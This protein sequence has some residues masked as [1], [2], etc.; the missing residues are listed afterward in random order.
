MLHTGLRL[1]SD[2]LKAQLPEKVQAAVQADVVAARLAKQ[3]C[4]WLPAAGYAPPGLLERAAF[5]MRM[6]GGLI[7]AGK[8]APDAR[9]RVR[10]P[11]SREHP[12]VSESAVQSGPLLGSKKCPAWTPAWGEAPAAPSRLARAWRER[13]GCQC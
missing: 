2:L 9:A 11:C 10:E 6:R 7:A 8:R 12:I 5:R 1:A 4:R 13:R 3:C